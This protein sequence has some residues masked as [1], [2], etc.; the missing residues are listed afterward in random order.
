MRRQLARSSSFV[1]FAIFFVL[2]FLSASVNAQGGQTQVWG[3]EASVA[4]YSGQDAY[5]TTPN[6]NISTGTWTGG[7]N[8]V[9][10]KTDT[11]MESGPTKACDIDCGLHPYGSW[12]NKLGNGFENVDT[13]LVLL[14]G[15]QYEYYVINGIGGKPNK[16]AAYFCAPAACYQMVSGNLRMSSVPYI[17]S[18]GESSSPGVH[19][20]SITT[21]YN[22]YKDPINGS[23]YSW[24]YQYVQNN[25][26][27]TVSAC[28]SSTHAWTASY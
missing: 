1:V 18:G 28:N 25:V 27:G 14:A 17:A 7:P 23:W 8:G 3:Y 26:N 9:T 22:K 5:L 20:G 19:W 21:L 4:G 15:Q 16:W 24:C 12:H 2:V 11:F 10:N 6:P 13:G